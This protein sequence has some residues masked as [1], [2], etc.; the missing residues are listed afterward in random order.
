MTRNTPQHTKVRVDLGLRGT[1]G[2]LRNPTH[3]GLS[4]PR[5]LALCLSCGAMVMRGCGARA[6]APCL[7][8]SHL[9]LNMHLA[10]TGAR[11]EA[12]RSRCIGC[13]A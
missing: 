9:M 3:H 13:E 7:T 5:T 6:R 4:I 10:E 1:Q 8:R 2:V 12:P 11:A